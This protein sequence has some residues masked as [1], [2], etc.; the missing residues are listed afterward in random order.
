M[1]WTELGA[2]AWLAFAPAEA[3]TQRKVR[4]L[5]ELYALT[6]QECSEHDEL[7]QRYELARSEAE[8]AGGD[9]LFELRLGLV[10]AKLLRRAQTGRRT[11]DEKITRELDALA[12]EASR[13]PRAE[14]LAE[15]RDSLAED[16]RNPCAT[17]VTPSPVLSPSPLPATRREETPPASPE[18]ALNPDPNPESK[19][20][21]VLPPSR[22]TRAE[23]RMVASGSVV[24]AA[25]VLS[26]AY[27]IAGPFL[28]N[29]RISGE[30][31]G[32]QREF[33]ISVVPRRAGAWVGVGS[34]LTGVGTGLVV[35]GL[36]HRRCRKRR[37]R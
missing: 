8:A 26:V 11:D 22:W 29:A 21:F 33:L 32:A 13:G 17:S 4:L 10:R 7:V 3:A 28:A 34:V 30:P 20:D 37:C 31:N 18:T 6:E 2:V 15:L 14:S 25:G 9:G 1:S 19:P 5:D 16:V 12:L 35:Y 36:T 24:G 27:G 23:G